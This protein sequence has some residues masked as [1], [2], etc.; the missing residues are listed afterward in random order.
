MKIYLDVC[1]LCRP[2]DNQL[3][4]KIRL[5]SEA[6]SLLL[7]LVEN[8]QI[9]LINSE[10]V[11]F[12]VSKISNPE[13]RFYVELLLKKCQKRIIIN[14]KI[15][16]R[17][18]FFESQNIKSLDSLH[19]ACA[20]DSADIFFTV[21]KELYEKARKIKNLKTKIMNPIQFTFKE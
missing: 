6:I 8:K 14:E 1:C 18:L 16:K 9:S 10:I 7:L 2:F 21:D 15:I 12:E 13:K 5:E 11:E 20:E 3:I 4:S 17:A 19:L